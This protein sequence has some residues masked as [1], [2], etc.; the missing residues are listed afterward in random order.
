MLELVGGLFIL[1]SLAGMLSGPD[2]L[3]GLKLLSSLV[4]PLLIMVIYVEDQD[5]GFYVWMV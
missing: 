2:A 5:K 4:S 1:R 3:C